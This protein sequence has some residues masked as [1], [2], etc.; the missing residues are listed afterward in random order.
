V[1]KLFSD[2]GDDILAECGKCGRVLKVP[3]SRAEWSYGDY[4]VSDGV[5]CPCGVLANVISPLAAG[6]PDRVGPRPAPSGP[7]AVRCPKCRSEQVGAN[8]KGFGLGKAA[9]GGL[10]LGP[11]GLL[12]GLF[13]SKKVRVSCLNCGHSWSP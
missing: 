12:A 2:D 3:R 5:R 8:T 7:P 4:N 13:G 9:V 11:V 1:F 6:G 10:A